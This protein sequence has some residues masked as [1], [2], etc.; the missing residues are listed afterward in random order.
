MSSVVKENAFNC[1]Y[2]EFVAVFLSNKF[3]DNVEQ[4]NPKENLFFKHRRQDAKLVRDEQLL[5]A[6]AKSFLFFAFFNGIG[7]G[8][9]VTKCFISEMKRRKRSSC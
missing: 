9:K 1:C 6:R 2:Y 7:V 5:D 8:R 3:V 4:K